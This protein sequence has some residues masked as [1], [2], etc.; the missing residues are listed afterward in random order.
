M[1]VLFLLNEGQIVDEKFMVYINDLLSSGEI[2]DLFPEE[3]IDNIVAACT[4]GA[5]AAG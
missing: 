4:N 5:K 3:E 2:N 1:G